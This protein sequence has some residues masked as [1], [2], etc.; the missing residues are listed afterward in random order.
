MTEVAIWLSL[1]IVLVGIAVIIHPDT[2][3]S[4]L[5]KH[6]EKPVVHILAVVIR[7]L[8][9]LLLLAVADQSS[10]P[11]ALKILGWV[12]LI[13]AL[14]LALIGRNNFRRLMAWALGF[15]KQY[16][17]MG[18]LLAMILGGFIIYALA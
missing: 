12:S 7:F 5:E 15:P 11:M 18:G 4:V 16:R 1:L 6:A 14:A 9:G 8:F 2:V 13:A 17:R 10:L 3:F